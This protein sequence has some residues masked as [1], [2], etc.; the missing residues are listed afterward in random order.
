MTSAASF[1]R[2]I[3]SIDLTIDRRAGKMVDAT[4][5]NHVVTQTVAKDP[6]TTEILARYKT[7]SDPIGNRVIGRITRTSTRR[8]AR[9]TGPTPPVS[10]RWAT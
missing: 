6:G 2:L 7:I 1:G 4:A 10:S 3:T 9:S 8:A 5:E